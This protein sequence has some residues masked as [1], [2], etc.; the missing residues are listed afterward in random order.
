MLKPL[1]NFV[2]IEIQDPP[3][4]TY[5]G[6]MLPDTARD[7]PAP[8][9]GKVVSVGPGK[10]NAHG[11]ELVPMVLKAGQTVYVR[12]GGTDIERDKVKYRIVHEDD[13]LCVDE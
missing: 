3:K 4:Q 7:K 8:Q 6:I 9:R 12:W 13:V 1:S 10:W 5:G 11:T 2:V